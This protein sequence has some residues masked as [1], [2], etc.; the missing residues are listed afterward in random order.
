MAESKYNRFNSFKILV[1]AERLRAIAAGGLPFPIDWHIYPSNICNHS[2]GWCMFRQNE[3]QFLHREM[4]PG[5]LLLRAVADAARTG[6]RLVH[7]SGGGEPLLNRNTIVAI[8]KASELGMAVALS[9]NGSLLSPEIAS[10]VDYIRVSVNAGT[11]QQHDETNHSDDLNSDWDRVVA[12]I[13]NAVPSKKKDIG[14][15]FVA[16]HHNWRDIYPFCK[17]AAEAKV[18]FVQIRPA[19]WYDPEKNVAT[20]NVVP[21]VAEEAERAKSDFGEILEIFATDEK[22]SGYWTPRTYKQCHAVLTGVCLTATGDFAVCQDRTDLRFGKE[23]K[24]GASFEEVWLSKEHRDLVATI[25]S[26]GV[27]DGCPRCVWNNRNEIIEELFIK[28]VA[29]LDLI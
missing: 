28:D 29:R 14:L 2:C 17:M 16:D 8:R 22:F 23:Y 18:D 24:D 19:F 4:I 7:F 26:P 25:N 5:G 10:S 21:N 15:A 11:K 20:K 13:R 3:E 6:A 27:L 1:H 12:N 9:T